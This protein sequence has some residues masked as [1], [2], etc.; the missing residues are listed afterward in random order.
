VRIHI[1]R[2]L[3]A[4]NGI[5]AGAFAQHSVVSVAVRLA[6]GGSRGGR[7]RPLIRGW[8]ADLVPMDVHIGLPLPVLDHWIQR[9]STFSCV[10][11]ARLVG[12]GLLAASR[13]VP[14][15]ACLAGQQELLARLLLPN[16]GTRAFVLDLDRRQ[17]LGILSHDFVDGQNATVLQGLFTV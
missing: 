14:L 9:D 4:H 15:H 5:D 7:Q 2:C 16:L 13:L 1:Q 12:V 3:Q 10:I 17:N 11:G 8:K 6:R